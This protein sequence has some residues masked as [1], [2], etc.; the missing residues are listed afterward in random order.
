M[1]SYN[2][3]LSICAAASASARLASQPDMDTGAPRRSGRIGSALLRAGLPASAAVYQRL[4]TACEAQL[5]VGVGDAGSLA[6]GLRLR[7][8]L[9]SLDESGAAEPITCGDPVL[10]AAD[11]APSSSSDVH[12]TTELIDAGAT[13]DAAAAAAAAAGG[14]ARGPGSG[15]SRARWELGVRNV[16]RRVV[17]AAATASRVKALASL[18]RQVI[19]LSVFLKSRNVRSI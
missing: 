9:R 13:Y 12:E 14:E 15:A 18:A 10:S 8:Y 5:E 4:R 1:T 17:D 7:E 16:V 6:A 2:T 19:Y 3:L 11:A